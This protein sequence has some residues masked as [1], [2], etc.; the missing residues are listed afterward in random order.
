MQGALLCSRYADEAVG[1]VTEKPW[2][3]S[4]QRQG[5]L[6]FPKALRQATGLLGAPDCKGYHGRFPLILCFNQ[7]NSIIKIQ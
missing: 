1:L 7:Q 3:H 5:I 6:S 2:F 4:R